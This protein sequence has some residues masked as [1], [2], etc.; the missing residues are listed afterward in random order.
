MLVDIRHKPN[1]NDKQ[2][3]DWCIHYGFNPIV[4]ATKEDKIKRSQKMKR[5][6]EIE[7]TLGVIEGTPVRP[8][9]FH[10]CCPTDKY[11]LLPHT[12]THILKTAAGTLQKFPCKP[13]Y[14]VF[15]FLS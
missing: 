3:Y 7:E 9:A 13:V 2:M 8:K 15:S 14:S 1:E 12:G 5:V 4:V 10:R 6:R 11:Q